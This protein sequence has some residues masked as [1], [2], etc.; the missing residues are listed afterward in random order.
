[1]KKLI[2]GLFVVLVIVAC[3]PE[4]M[5]FP[6][7]QYWGTYWDMGDAL[8]TF[9]DGDKFTVYDLLNDKFIVEE[10]QYTVDG[11][12]ITLLETELCGPGL[13]EG[14]YRWSVDENG[15]LKLELQGDSC[16]GRTIHETRLELEE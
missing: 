12:T 10:G 14:V 5:S 7:G 3:T 2:A 1:M 9:E 13:V 11:D 15:H 4:T 6:K 8:I 16:F